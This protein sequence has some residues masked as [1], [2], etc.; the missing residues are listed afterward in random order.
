MI[1]ELLCKSSQFLTL[2]SHS[3][4]PLS[5]RCMITWWQFCGTLPSHFTRQFPVSLATNASHGGGRTVATMHWLLAKP[6]RGKTFEGL[7]FRKTTLSSLP[8]RLYFH[9]RKFWRSWQDGVARLRMQ[10]PGLARVVSADAFDCQSV[11]AHPMPQCGGVHRLSA[12]REHVTTGGRISRPSARLEDTTTSPR[13]SLHSRSSSGWCMAG[14]HRT[15][16]I[17]SM[18][19]RAAFVGEQM[20]AC[21]GSWT[22]CGCLKTCTPSA[23]SST[24]V[25]LLTPF[26]LR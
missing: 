6:Q 15:S 16:R 22:H 1:G 24:S 5:V 9:R 14:S 17:A 8:R 3:A 20:L 19:A 2:N 10:D 23:P 25:K 18:S 4:V 13:T 11:A 21:T 26:G 7:I 12:L